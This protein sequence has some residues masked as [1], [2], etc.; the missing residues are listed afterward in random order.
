MDQ[1]LGVIGCKIHLSPGWCGG[2]LKF[3]GNEVVLSLRMGWIMV[4]LI[5]EWSPM[6]RSHSKQTH[7]C[8]YGNTRET[9]GIPKIPEQERLHLQTNSALLSCSPCAPETHLARGHSLLFME[10]CVSF[11]SVDALNALLH[12]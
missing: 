1:D 5:R 3:V 4:N 10:F 12:L 11:Y 7:A 9:S 6:R 2:L 8:S